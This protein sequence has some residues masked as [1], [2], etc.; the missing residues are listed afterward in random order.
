MDKVSRSM[1]RW[2]VPFLVESKNETTK[3]EGSNQKYP[4]LPLD[5]PSSAFLCDH[6]EPLRK[7]PELLVLL[8]ARALAFLKA[9]FQPS[10]KHKVATFLW[11]DYKDFEMLSDP[12]RKGVWPLAQ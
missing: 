4:T 2:L 12:E 8:K 3:L 7:D 6:C 5:L 10:M 9:K 1:L 11:P